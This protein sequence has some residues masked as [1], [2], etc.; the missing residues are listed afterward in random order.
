MYGVGQM[1]AS[2]YSI[3]FGGGLCGAVI[4]A[5]LYCTL[6]P[7]VS[8]YYSLLAGLYMLH[9]HKMPFKISLLYCF[10]PLIS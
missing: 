10:S 6:L 2:C 3:R 5:V 7:S 8:L 4:G 9:V 1:Q